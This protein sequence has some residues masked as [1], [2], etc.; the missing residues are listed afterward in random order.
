MVVRGVN[1]SIAAD[2]DTDALVFEVPA[3]FTTGTFVL[4]VG[5]PRAVM[6]TAGG[7]LVRWLQQTQTAEVASRLGW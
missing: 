1:T 6:D 7:G 5:N 4:D 3:D 2:R